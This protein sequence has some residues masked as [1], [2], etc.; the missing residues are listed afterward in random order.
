[1][2]RMK[3]YPAELSADEL[4]MP[5]FDLGLMKETKINL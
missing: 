2:A 1:M 5:S 3:M 4:P